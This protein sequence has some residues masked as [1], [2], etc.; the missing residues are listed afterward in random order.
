MDVQIVVS[1]DE[2]LARYKVSASEYL[3]MIMAKAMDVIMPAEL[4]C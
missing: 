2:F 1:V 3:P 4:F